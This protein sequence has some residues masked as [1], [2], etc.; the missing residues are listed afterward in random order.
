M[1][2]FKKKS[3]PISER[4]RALTAEIAALES[5][6]KQLSAQEKAA[7]PQAANH[8][9]PSPPP[10]PVAPAPQPRLRSTTVPHHRH[11]GASI[12]HAAPAHEPVFEPM[13]RPQTVRHVPA[14]KKRDDLG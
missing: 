8:H 2:F 14:E 10:P 7:P 12:A 9:Q 11:G 6:I 13:A 4:A 1:A 3:D 5:K